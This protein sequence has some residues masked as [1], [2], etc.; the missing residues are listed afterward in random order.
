TSREWN[1]LGEVVWAVLDRC[2][3]M[4]RDRQ[5]TLEIPD[6]LPLALFDAGLLDQALVALLENVASH[7]PPGSPA[8][9]EGSAQQ[10]D[11]R[12]AI[13][14]AGPGIPD[15]DRER[16]F[17]KYE[18]LDAHQPGVGL[19]LA[20]ARAAVQAQGGRLWVEQSERGGAR[21]VILL[22]NALVPVTGAS[23]G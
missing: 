12:L 20:I 8:W 18:R 13:R 1:D 14:D 11:L 2:Q 4:L 3:P 6:N 7:T 17:S 19:G 16:V 9:I 21:F 22:S 5:I 15:A 10:A 23:R